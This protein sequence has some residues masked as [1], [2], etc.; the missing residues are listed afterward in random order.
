MHWRKVTLVGVGLLGGSL[1]LALRAR[2]LAGQVCGFVRRASAVTECEGLGVVD[3]ATRDLREAVS[4]ADLIVLCSPIGQ[5]PELLAEI[6]A[7]ASS[8]AVVTDVGSV[9]ASLVA[10]LEPIARRSGLKYVGSHPMAGSEKTGPRAA[11]GDLFVGATCI[12]TPTATSDPVAVGVVNQLWAAVGGQVMTLTPQAHDELVSRSSHLPHVTAAAL[13]N[14]VLSPAH[15][16]QQGQVCA[17]GFR[18]TTRV[19]G[20]SPQMW[21]DIALANRPYLSRTLGVYIE[22]LMEFRRAL[23]EGNAAVIEE[24]F[25]VAKQRRDAWAQATTN[26]SAE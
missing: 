21:R 13:A 7:A 20:G 8:S 5:M 23:D 2:Q 14:Y 10:Q 19:A 25:T 4:G 3:S 17:G 1:G 9:K 15:P 12:V 24:F 26:E 16:K 11:K 22:D 6:A 18:D